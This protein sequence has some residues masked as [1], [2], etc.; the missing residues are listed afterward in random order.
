[1]ERVI[2]MRTMHLGPEELLV[3]VKIAVA[4]TARAAD[5]ATTIDAAERAMREAEPTA[6]VIYVEP[7]IFVEGHAPEPRPEPPA[8]VGH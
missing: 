7:D 4:R 1:V 3:A 8:A 5:V 6:S 2:H